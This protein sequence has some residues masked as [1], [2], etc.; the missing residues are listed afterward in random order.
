[1]RVGNAAVLLEGMND[2]GVDIVDGDFHGNS[3][4]EEMLLP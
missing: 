2:L 4:W 3:S 1:L